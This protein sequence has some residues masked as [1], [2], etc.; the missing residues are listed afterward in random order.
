MSYRVRFTRAARDDLLRLHGFL[1]ERDPAAANRAR[2]AIRK[3]VGLLADFPF[4]CRK[5]EPENPF[6]REL[7]IEFGSSGY[8][9]LFEIEDDRNVTILALRHQREVDY[10]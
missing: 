6:L 2:Q 5:A 3:A 7:L 9:A 8:V 4:T 10:H 1:R